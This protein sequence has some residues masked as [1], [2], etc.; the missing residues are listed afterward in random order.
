MIRMLKKSPN[1]RISAV[2][3]LN[4]AYFASVDEGD[5]EYCDTVTELVKSPKISYP[6][7]ESP[8]LTTSNPLRKLDKTIKKDSCVEFKMGKD[9]VF[10]G[11][12]DTIAETTSTHNSVGKTFESVNIP[13]ISKFCAKNK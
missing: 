5:D 8:L 11:K 12:V 4:H 2:E 7:C 9:N 13:K 10:T 1:D 3:A 6:S